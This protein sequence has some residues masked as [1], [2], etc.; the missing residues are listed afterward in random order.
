MQNTTEEFE[1]RLEKEIILLKN[2]Q[3]EKKVDSC[4][5][6]EL[7]IGCKKRNEYVDSVYKSMNKGGGGGFDF[8]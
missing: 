4:L 2:C 5:K 6:C 7:V 3:K 8:N 1:Q